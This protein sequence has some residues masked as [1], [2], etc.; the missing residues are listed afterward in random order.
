MVKENISE[1]LQDF[2]AKRTIPRLSP[3][4]TSPSRLYIYIYL[5]A[6]NQGLDDGQDI[7][8]IRDYLLCIV[9]GRELLDPLEDADRAYD[10]L[11][12]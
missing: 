4:S 10:G 7:L 6:C 3:F 8:H 11:V 1:L 2:N 9:G 5:C 12:K